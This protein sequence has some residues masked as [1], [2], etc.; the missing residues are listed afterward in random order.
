[1]RYLNDLGIICA[2]GTNKEQ[3][4]DNLLN[5]PE[6]EYLSVYDINGQEIDHF[7]SG[8]VTDEMID[9]QQ[10]NGIHNTRNNRLLLNAFKQIEATLQQLRAGV[11]DERIAV[12]I[13]TSTSGI[14]EG[15]AARKAFKHSGDYP[16]HFS[17]A[18]QEMG[19]PSKFLAEHINAEGPAYAISTAC[20]SSAKALAS[21][22]SLID[23]DLADI[24]ICGGVDT[25]SELPLRGFYALQSTAERYC[26]PMARERDGINLGESATLFVMSKFESAICF[27]GFGESS[28]AYHIS[29]PEPQGSGAKLAISKAL[30]VA[31]LNADAI[32]YVN[33]HGTATPK[34]DEMEANVIA[35]IFGLATPVS[36][37][38][39]FTGHTLGGAGALEAGILW[40]I[41][42][43]HYNL[44]RTLPMNKSDFGMDTSLPKLYLANGQNESLKNALSNSFAF[45][46]NNVA[47]ILGLSN[48]SDHTR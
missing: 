15:E 20:S 27:K 36:S 28:D 25:L 18:Q 13:G 19:A 39:R 26:N 38:K 48:E 35:D 32:D 14:K 22:Q 37:T 46:G 11:G 41:L 5:N 6:R 9:T 17:Y 47:V 45:G 21:A 23:A 44:T 1:M 24:V 2:L 43:K 10:L 29:A 42:N 12:V 30:E 16:E 7:Y 31:G 40:L 3:I 4:A 8:R 34:N 33:M